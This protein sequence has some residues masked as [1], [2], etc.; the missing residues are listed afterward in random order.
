[1]I[2]KLER[3]KVM[4]IKTKSNTEPPQT[5]LIKQQ[6][7]NNR[8]TTLEWKAAWDT[9]GGSLNAFYWQQIFALDFIEHF[10]TGFLENLLINVCIKTLRF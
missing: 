4:H 5:M 1:M 6:I 10:C 7:T 8:T 2:V 3:Y 9:W